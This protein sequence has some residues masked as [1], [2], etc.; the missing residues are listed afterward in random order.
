MINAASAAPAPAV[1]AGLEG[2]YRLHGATIHRFCLSQLQDP[3]LAEDATSDVFAVALGGFHRL[4]SE[5]EALFWLLGI[6]RRVVSGHRRSRLRQQRLGERAQSALRH[7]RTVHEHV[8]VRD[9]LRRVTE[10]I[11]LLGRRDRTL[12]GLRAAAQLSYAEIA[13]VMHLTEG[14]ARV[15]THRALQRLR[16]RLEASR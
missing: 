12:V 15:A 11:A 8:A 10:G 4:G 14:A 2:I 7:T 6:A 16:S 3:H 5:D 9:E 13:E 1:R